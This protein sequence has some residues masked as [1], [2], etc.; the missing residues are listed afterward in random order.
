MNYRHTYHAGNAADVVKHAIVALIL[1]HLKRKD[2][3]F[4]VLDSHAGLGTYD[5]AAAEAE[6]TGEWRSGIGRLL[7]ESSPPEEVAEYLAV[8]RRLNPEGGLRWYPGSPA[9]AAALTRPQDRLAFV[10]L[11]PDDQGALRRRFVN[12]RRVGIHHGDGYAALKSLLPPPERRGLVLIDPP[13]EAGDETTVLRRNLGEALK[14]WRGGI[15]VIWYP[16]KRRSVVDRFHA[17]LAMLGPPPT[18]V[19][20]VTVRNGEDSKRRT[21]GE[22]ERLVGSGLVI[23]NPPW[24]L[25]GAL[26]TLLPQLAAI[27]A[28][29][30]GRHRLEWLVAETPPAPEQSD[31]SV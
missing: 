10:E 31:S 24:Q 4:F 16:I 8:V 17:D 30:I 6:K 29:G 20:E 26:A 22:S 13:Y 21:S 11:H 27:L 9:L 7:A 18:L 3:P 15:F 19:A 5:L 28:P 2:A 1:A 14:R 23:V 12:D 25:D